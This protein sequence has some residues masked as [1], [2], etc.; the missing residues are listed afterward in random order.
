MIQQTPSTAFNHSTNKQY[1]KDWV[2]KTKQFTIIRS[3]ILIDINKKSNKI[4]IKL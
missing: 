4:K 1:E 2:K 3:Y